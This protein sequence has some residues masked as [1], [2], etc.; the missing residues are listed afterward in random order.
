MA[1]LDKKTR[2]VPEAAKEL[3]VHELTLRRAIARGEIR[4]VRVGRRVLVPSAALDDF[5]A[6]TM[7]TR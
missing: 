5:L 2:T 7:A 3:G 6:G 1:Q 4:A